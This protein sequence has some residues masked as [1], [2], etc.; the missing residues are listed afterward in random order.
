MET[1]LISVKAISQKENRY[2]IC[3][4]ENEWFS[5]FG[6]CPCNKGDRVEIKF[7]TTTSNGR[8]FNNIKEIKVITPAEA[9]NPFKTADKLE[10]TTNEKA[11]TMLVSYCKD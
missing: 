11:L 6:K 1:K 9:V 3:S 5:D 2:S 8:F 7:E 4:L 10:K